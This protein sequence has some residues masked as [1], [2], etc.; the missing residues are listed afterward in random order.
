MPPNRPSLPEIVDRLIGRGD[1]K[2]RK[3]RWPESD[4]IPVYLRVGDGFVTASRPSPNRLIDLIGPVATRAIPGVRVRSFTYSSPGR[5]YIERDTNKS[6]K[7]RY[8]RLFQHYTPRAPTVYLAYSLAAAYYV[9]GLSRLLQGESWCVENIRGLIL[10]QPAL[11]LNQTFVQQFESGE[12]VLVPFRELQYP[13][14]MQEFADGL[15][16]ICDK[17]IPIS[18]VRWPGDQIVD[19]TDAMVAKLPHAIKDCPVEI[20]FEDRGRE[21]AKQD[22]QNHCH[23]PRKDSPKRRIH[24]E[25]RRMVLR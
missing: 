4:P 3:L 5:H 17:K 13:D 11:C 18:L 12:D 23:V 2:E 22:F 6:I 9:L 24:E 16:R 19:C 15:T 7:Q 25:L 1:A 10:L 21:Q 8:W 14:L 20:D